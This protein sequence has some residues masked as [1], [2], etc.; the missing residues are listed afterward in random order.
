MK[1]KLRPPHVLFLIDY[2]GNP[3]GGEV[4]LVKT[5]RLMPQDRIRCSVAALHTRLNSVLVDQLPHMP[6]LFPIQR[7][8]D[9]KALR[10]ARK[11]RRLLRS[12]QVDIVHT[13]F[14][15]SN[16]WGGLACK[17][18]GGPLLVTSRRDMGILRR[19]RKHLAAYKLVNSLCDGVVAVSH[20]VRNSCVRNEGLDP[21]KISVIYNGVE[22]DRIDATPV[23]SGL[24]E[25]WGFGSDD[26]IIV[27]VGNVRWFKG[28]DV[29]VQAAA[30]VCREFPSARF[31]I[32][33]GDYEPEYSK[34]IHEL[35]RK[36]GL[37]TNVIFSGLSDSVISIL[38]ASQI[39]CLLSRTEGFSNAI[40]E[41]MACSLPCVVTDV[42]GNA[43]AIQDGVSGYVVQPENAELAAQRLLS[44]LG[45]PFKIAKMGSHA[46]ADAEDKFAAN[47]MVSNLA[48]FYE[49][50]LGRSN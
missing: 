8:Y 24:R 49:S 1:P 31:L 41:A 22:L 26:P 15:T 12:E 25:R 33:G 5:V 45:D 19:S 35:V 46:R 39:F 10:M 14:E 28:I 13:Y 44:L 21:D 40:L 16:L 20:A 27:A 37:E 9:F 4:N 38:K 30:L 18:G 48:S 2:L 34:P 7:M 36:L 17:L 6:Y 3:G 43:E 23:D 11:F 47:K 29:L 50:L 42:G 32:V